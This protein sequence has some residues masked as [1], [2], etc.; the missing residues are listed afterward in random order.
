MTAGDAIGPYVSQ[1]LWK[2][3][4]Y[5]S[6][7]I[8]QKIRTNPR[9]LDFLTS[10]DDWLYVQNGGVIGS[11]EFDAAPR[12]IRNSRDLSAYVHRDFTYQAF[13]NA[14]LILGGL[15]VP[16]DAA[17]PYRHSL[18]QSSFATFGPPHILDFVARVTNAGLKAGWYQKW[19]VHR[20]LRPEEYAGRIHTTRTGTAKYSVHADVLGSAALESTFARTRSYLLPQAYPEGAPTHPSYPAGHAIVAGACATVLK[21]FYDEAYVIQDPVIASSDGLSLLPYNA[22]N[23]TVGGELNKLAANISF[24]RDAAGVHWRSDGV[25]GL[26]LGEAVAMSILAESKRCY[27]ERFD[28]FSLTKFDGTTVMI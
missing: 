21:A 17:N 5:G 1:F 20:R 11:E 12:Y 3:V 4:P 25:Y 28:G 26:L 18:T 13:L 19:I 16:V 27:N 7:P 10:F 22:A 6:T 14:A 23:L 15:N 24:A 2:P 8:T 9:G